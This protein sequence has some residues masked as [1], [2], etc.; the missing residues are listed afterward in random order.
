VNAKSMGVC[1]NECPT[2]NSYTTYYCLNGINPTVS[3]VANYL[4]NGYCIYQ[5][6][7]TPILNRCVI[8]NMTALAEFGMSK[9]YS[10]KELSFFTQFY[11]DIIE[12]RGYIFG[13]GFCVA[14]IL[15]FAW[16]WIMRIP[17]LIFAAVWSIC[18]AVVGFLVILGED[19]A[20]L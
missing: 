2:T 1:L 8:Q 5:Y 6:A 16:C 3:N 7:T 18:I 11:G 10:T 13:F 4:S 20:L 12:A 15:G 9:V 17:G 14:L 19:G